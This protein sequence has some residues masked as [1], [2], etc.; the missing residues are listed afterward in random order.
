MTPHEID[1]LKRVREYHAI[2]GTAHEVRSVSADELE[3]LLHLIDQLWPY[4]HA[5][6]QCI[7]SQVMA[8]APVTA[9][10]L[11]DLPRRAAR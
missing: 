5:R 11:P 6:C 2:A 10:D 3:V 9:P 8:A 1:T 7:F 4:A